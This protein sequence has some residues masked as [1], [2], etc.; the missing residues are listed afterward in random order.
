MKILQREYTHKICRLV[1]KREN[2]WPCETEDNSTYNSDLKI[3][4]R[5][6]G[7]D[8]NITTMLN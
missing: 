8:H 6:Q 3:F 4:E 5:A 1:G 7:P 2:I